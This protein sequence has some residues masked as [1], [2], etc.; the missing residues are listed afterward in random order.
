MRCVTLAEGTNMDFNWVVILIRNF[1]EL[2]KT[3]MLIKTMIEVSYINTQ[4][5]SNLSY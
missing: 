2:D 4:S 1:M 5:R 3:F